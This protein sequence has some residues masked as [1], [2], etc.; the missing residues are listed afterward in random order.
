MNR[1][2]CKYKETCGKKETALM[3]S[4][5]GQYQPG[6]APETNEVIYSPLIIAL[7]QKKRKEVSYV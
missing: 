6:S 4:Q 2:D 7:L 5:G 1:R 3:G